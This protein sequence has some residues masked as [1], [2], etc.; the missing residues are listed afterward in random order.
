MTRT[1]LLFH[2]EVRWLL[3]GFFSLYDTVLEF[4]DAKDS[5][6]KKIESKGSKT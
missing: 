3:K 4:I 1:R 2:T 6:L 5:I